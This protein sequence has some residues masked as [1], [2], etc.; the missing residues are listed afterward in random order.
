MLVTQPS[1]ITKLGVQWEILS[2]KL[3]RETIGE[4]TQL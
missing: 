4:D 2:L 3:R 1:Q